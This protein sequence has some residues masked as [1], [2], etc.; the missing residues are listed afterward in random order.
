M[1]GLFSLMPLL[2]ATA[3]LLFVAGCSSAP[4]EDVSSGLAEAKKNYELGQFQEA[5]K[6]LGTVLDESPENVEAMRVMAL[7][8]AAQGKNDEAIAQYV[9]LVKVDPN[10]DVSWY[11]MAL[12]ER[13]IGE[14]KKAVAHFEKALKVKQGDASYTDELA[15][16]EMSL[17]G[18]ERA[19]ALWGEL[20]DDKDSSDESRKELLLLQ[21]QA[22]QAAKDYRRARKAFKAALKLDP[23]DEALRDRVESFD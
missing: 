12:L 20:L 2:L 17:G 22:Y 9:A 15:R 14:P 11:R 21:G 8:L 6:A 10:D 13:I 5:E 4:S 1:R 19:A 7:A 23:S 3:A 18:Y 16:T